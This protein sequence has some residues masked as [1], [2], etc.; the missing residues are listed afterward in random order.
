MKV[1]LDASVALAAVLPDERSDS[2][3]AA[4]TVALRDGLIVP[5]LWAY[6]VQNGLATALR[7]NR[8][9]SETLDQ[10]LAA[11]R[12]FDA[13]MEPPQ[14]LGLE[15]QLARTH[16]LSAYDAAYLAVAQ[17]AGAKLATDDR[18]LREAAQRVGVALFAQSG[19]ESKKRTAR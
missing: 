1:V 12:R 17:A 4:L 2:A 5:S 13:R 7:R 16:E 10:A 15:L 18:K 9:D 14:G 8:L 6:E 3:R 11:L 19:G